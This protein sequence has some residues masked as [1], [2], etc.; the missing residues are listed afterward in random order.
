MSSISRLW[1]L[2]SQ[3]HDQLQR[4]EHGLC[5]IPL[6][7]VPTRPLPLPRGAPL[8]AHGTRAAAHKVAQSTFILPRMIFSRAR[9]SPDQDLVA[10]ELLLARCSRY[11]EHEALN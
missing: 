10:R 4:L 5:K 6:M 3:A 1:G 8:H 9:R 7:L 11:A 2:R